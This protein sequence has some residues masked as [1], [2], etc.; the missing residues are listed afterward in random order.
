[1]NLLCFCVF[2]QFQGRN[3]SRADRTHRSRAVP[4]T[5]PGDQD[6]TNEA[7]EAMK[8]GVVRTKESAQEMKEKAK[9]KTKQ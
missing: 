3:E 6:L 8:E 5:Q 7:K 9:E 4:V 2:L 1:M